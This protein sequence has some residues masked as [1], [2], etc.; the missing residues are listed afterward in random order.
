ML[1]RLQQAF[2][3]VHDEVIRLEAVGESRRGPDDFL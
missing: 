2:V 3:D 1:A